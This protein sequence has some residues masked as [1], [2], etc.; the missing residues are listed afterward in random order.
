MQEIQDHSVIKPIDTSR[1]E[2]EKQQLEN[3][4]LML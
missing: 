4:A 2:E 1:M 3:E